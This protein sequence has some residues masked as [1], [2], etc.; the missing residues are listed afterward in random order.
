MARMQPLE[1]LQGQD[2]RVVVGVF[3]VG[4]GDHQLRPGRPGGIGVLPV[5]LV[6]VFRRV[7]VFPL[8]QQIEAGVVELLDGALHVVVLLLIGE[9]VAGRDR[10]SDSQHERQRAQAGGSGSGRR[11]CGRC[12]GCHGHQGCRD[13]EG[14][15][16]S[17]RCPAIAGAGPH[18]VPDTREIADSGRR[19]GSWSTPCLRSRK[20]HQHRRAGDVN[21]ARRCSAHP[22][23]VRRAGNV[24]A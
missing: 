21:L 20:A 14:W 7:L 11:N 6:E 24:P 9:Q 18:Q 13:G 3:V 17:R 16:A 1:A 22:L 12:C 15:V 5:D 10:E 8:L 2:R 19:K 23:F 4:V